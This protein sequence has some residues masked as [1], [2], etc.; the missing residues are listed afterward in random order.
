MTDDVDQV[1]EDVISPLAL[2]SSL[3]V[4]KLLCYKHT[5]SH[6]GMG[7]YSVYKVNIWPAQS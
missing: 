5:I 4:V 2:L 6:Q 1:D 3:I 7:A